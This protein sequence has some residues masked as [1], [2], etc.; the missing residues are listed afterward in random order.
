MF[1]IGVALITIY[2]ERKIGKKADKIKRGVE[3]LNFTT[4][5]IRGIEHFRVTQKKKK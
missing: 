2:I 5:V 3:N 4:V 1:D